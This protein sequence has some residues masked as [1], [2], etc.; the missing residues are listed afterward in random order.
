[1]ALAPRRTAAL[2]T[3][4]LVAGAIVATGGAGAAFA[5]ADPVAGGLTSG[6]V[7][8]P[9]QGNSGYDALHYDIDLSVNVA[10]SATNGAVATTTFSSATT[11]VRAATTGAPLSSYAFDFQGSASTLAASTLN[12]NSV[13]V[14]GEPATF[15]RI[16]NTTT[17]NATTDVHKLIVTP[18]TPVDGTFTT[19]VKYS[20]IPVKHTDTDGSSEGWNATTDGATFV[21]QPIGAM[22][23][24][25]NNNT[26]GDKATYTI[27]VNA[28]SKLTTSATAISANPGLKDAAVASNG[29][30][31]SK[32][33]S[34]DG[35]R[36]T[37][38]WD[39]K[40]PM[41]TMSTLIS[42]GRYDVYESD[43]TL[44]SGRV[45]HEW[46]FID[47]AI[48]AG[49]QQITQ[50]TRTQIKPIIDFFETK[51]GAYP[52]NSVGF[53]TDVVPN[54]INYALE[55]QDRSFFP[56]SADLGT[57]I[58]E[59]AHQWF[60]DAISPRVWNDIWISEG[61]ATY[62]EQQVA[63]ESAGSTT[64]DT[65]QYYY[66]LWNSTGSSSGV[67]TTPPA[68]MTLASQLFGSQVYTRGAMT[69]EALRTSIGSVKFTQLMSE[70]HSRYSGTSRGTS[71]FIALAEEI[72]G[73]SL[74]TFFNTWLFTAGK[75]AVWPSKFSLNVG[76]PTAPLAAGE[77]GTFVVSSRNTGKVAQV[78][79]VVT[80]DLASTLDKATIGTLPANTTL[81]EST[82]TWTV[83]STA[84]GAT[85]TIEIPVTL[86]AETA[87]ST[88][89][90]TARA[91][92]LGSTCLDCTASLVI[93]ASPIA[94][95]GEPTI[96]G[97]TTV[98]E[99]LTAVTGEWSEGTTFAY[100]WFLNG[101][102][103][104]GATKSTYTLDGTTA[105][106]ALAVK[107]TGTN[108]TST[109]VIKTSASTALVAKAT[110][111]T[112]IPTITGTPQFGK[113]LTAVTDGWTP[114]TFFAYQWFANGTAVTSTNGGTGP[115]FKPNV[116]TQLGQT[117]TVR[118]TGTKFGYTTASTTSVA[119][120]AVIGN[121]FSSTPTPTITG[122]LRALSPAGTN[123]V[124][125][126]EDGT[127]FTY[128]WSSNGTVIS[129]ATALT[130]SPP[131]TMVGSS[132]SV[133][134]T[135]SKPGYTSV[136]KTS[137]PVTITAAVQTLSPT[138]VI[139]GTPQFGGSLS[140]TTGTWDTG[141]S[142]A[143]QWLL[144]GEVITGATA[145]TISPTA[146]MVGHMITVTVTSTRTGYVTVSKTS[147][148][149]LV[150]AASLVSTPTPTIT[151]TTKVD[152]ELTAVTGTWD[153]GVDLTYKWFADGE[154]I[155]G[156]THNTITLGAAQA[157]LPITVAVKGVKAGYTAVTTT[158][159][160]TE[161]VALG[162]LGDTPVPTITGTAKVGVELTAVAG[163]WDNG[164]VFSYKWF[165]DDE[166]IEGASTSKFTPGATHAGMV[167]SVEV[168]GTK[169]GYTVVSTTSDA[170]DE[171]ALG[172]L[173]DTPVPTI[174][175]T[176]KVGVKLTAVAGDWGT[177]VVKTFQWF[178]DDEAI[179]GAI[180]STFTPGEDRFDAV[181]TVAVTGVKP[182]YAPTTVTSEATGSVGPADLV[183]TPIPSIAGT[184]KVGV[185]LTALP[186]TWDANTEFS[187][188]WFANGIEIEGADE[189]E[190][191]PTA[192]EFGKQI[193]VAVTG[194]KAAHATVTKT[195][196]ATAV[197]A[198]G[199]LTTTPIPTFEGSFRVGQ[200]FEPITG[201]WDD[202]VELSYRWKRNGTSISGAN[203]AAYTFTVADFG[204]S[205]T[206]TVT[207]TKYGYKSVSTVSAKKT[208][209]AGFQT[210]KPTPVL[211]GNTKVGQTLRATA[212]FDAKVTKSYTWYANGKKISGTKSS[213]KLTKSHKGK[214]I[215]VKITAKKT[216]YTTI[217]VSSV[218]T[219]KIR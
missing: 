179:D 172:D 86:N 111:V 15:S 5:A 52:G 26:P 49:N 145:T 57:T 89:A 81:S 149:A 51:Y 100:Q 79:S 76:A 180:E 60:G 87:G 192:D 83:P 78:G 45:L 33:P 126:W 203:S 64:V 9:N 165:A 39:Q 75:P 96:T 32:T 40:K 84:V 115:T 113:T 167:I 143:V 177:G 151:G 201:D 82:L 35:S 14:N 50:T 65:E 195:S 48:S 208:V 22:T 58:H 185:L 170:T 140:V 24:F 129:G 3:L 114:G 117:I 127:T 68:K 77:T 196:V 214:N 159:A 93:G 6:D 10:V 206:V 4:S 147:A 200:E 190:F 13:T 107:V 42:I 122:T 63:Y 197:V 209:Y 198:A 8:F 216:G 183:T 53:V 34:E 71:E 61:T 130:Y 217:S 31:I 90:A 98:G 88:L 173:V 137:E 55:T 29:E 41:A 108:G 121:T 105:G 124:G 116:A 142:L 146:E 38:V 182:G 133:T 158:S 210:L 157:G 36:T 69:L 18:A 99:T 132:L 95:T 164:T 186:G 106:L 199:A 202:D 141:T 23:A 155:E 128:V 47:P 16:E 80:V 92:T 219:G 56:N 101:N 150:A 135:A 17:S 97:T 189:S 1:M 112:A 94:T 188:A 171:V 20:G 131:V 215:S 139:T 218:R 66:N 138:P 207:A 19:V 166:I 102:A 125:S 193:T 118:V 168:T 213:L 161:N 148:G 156:A 211:T 174:T 162:D 134:I 21:N 91:T 74:T 59:L 176:A 204:K 205:L 109:P 11:T 37:W 119:T 54:T 73:R 28:P 187:Y 46:T 163:D 154:A 104:T 136:T 160:A 144:D 67:W 85:S 103:I 70:W 44:A 120:S 181:I 30:L 123:A 43:I 191:A 62:T 110:L 194:T 212:T 7:M 2:L 153:E 152:Y 184:A 169:P 178:A 72:S 175:G 12:V 25:P 27:S